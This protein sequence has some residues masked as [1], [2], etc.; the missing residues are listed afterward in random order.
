MRPLP[1]FLIAGLLAGAVNAAPQSPPRPAAPAANAVP[2]PAPIGERLK[3]VADHGGQAI[4]V[5]HFDEVDI[6]LDGRLDEPVWAELPGYDNMLLVEPDTLAPARFKTVARF[7][8]TDRGLY[9]G[10]WNEQPPETLIQRLSS[11]DD[12]INRD[13]WGITI[14]TSGEGLYGY[15]FNINLG[16]SVLDGK[17]AP[18]RTFTREWDGPWEQRDGGGRGRLEPGGLP[19]VVDD[20]HAAGGRRAHHGHLHQPQGGLSQR[21][22]G[23]ARAAVQRRALHVRLAAHQSAGGEAEAATGLLPLCRRRRRQLARRHRAQR[24][25]R[26]VSGARRRTSK[27]PPRHTRISAP[28]NP[29]T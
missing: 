8:Y 18:E 20:D 27:S 21:A 1:A 28:W 25:G 3:L 13:G 16:G 9:V 10:V 2:A 11:R 24:G 29:T 12:Y 4:A 23:L 17:V 26:C 5:T 15:W 19:A 22:L 7:L 6:R 14:D